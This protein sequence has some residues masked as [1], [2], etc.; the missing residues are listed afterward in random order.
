MAK[1]PVE[2]ISSATGLTPEEITEI[3]KKRGL[4]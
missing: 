3:L 4:L 2:T 1:L